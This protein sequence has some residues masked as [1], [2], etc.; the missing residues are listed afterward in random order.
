MKKLLT[1]IALTF[2]VASCEPAPT[3]GEIKDMTSH[4]NKICLDGHVYYHRGYMLALKVTNNGLPERCEKIKN[5][6][7]DIK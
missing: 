7:G 5:I 4:F 1:I 6:K 3:T 2:L